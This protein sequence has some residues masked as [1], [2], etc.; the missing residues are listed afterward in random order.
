MPLS[1]SIPPILVVV[2][3]TASGKTAFAIEK[4]LKVGGEIISADSRQIFQETT[5]GTAKPSPEELA[6]VPHHFINELSL[7]EPFSAGLFAQQALQRIGDILERGKIPIVCG[8]STLYIQA[9]TQ[10][11]APVP[12][13]AP[14]IRQKLHERLNS[15]GKEALFDELS[16]IDP[17]FAQSLDATKTQRLLRGLEVWYGTGERLSDWH[18]RQLPPPYPF[19]IHFLQPP[20]DLLYERINQRV[21]EMIAQGLLKEVQ[22]ILTA[23][24]SPQLNPLRTI[25]YQEPIAHLNG[26]Y[27][28]DE[29]LR[30]L[31]QNT[32][33]YAK[34]QITW[35]KRYLTP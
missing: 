26:A 22:S 5:I 7:N 11:I 12:D 32:R 3:A 21:D 19:K 2:G 18:K 24:F 29:M 1:T 9:L 25:G 33:H 34:R 8:G 6:A 4:A 15:E 16:Q 31:K 17:I 27:P 20:R 10:G 14:E 35:F 28:F 30:L 13:I 23:G